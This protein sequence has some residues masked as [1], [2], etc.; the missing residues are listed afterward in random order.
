MTEYQIRFF[1]FTKNTRCC[2]SRVL[3]LRQCL[4]TSTR[5]YDL[6]KEKV[7]GF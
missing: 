6:L 1:L 5:Y 3:I 4:F 7:R 2:V